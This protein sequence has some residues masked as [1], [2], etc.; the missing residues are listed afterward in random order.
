MAI[1]TMAT[2]YQIKVQRDG[3]RF[4]DF[5]KGLENYKE[6]VSIELSALADMSKGL[7]PTGGALKHGTSL[8]LMYAFDETWDKSWSVQSKGYQKKVLQYWK[9]LSSY[10]IDD[11][12][13]M[14]LEAIDT[15]AIDDYIKVLRAKGNKPKT[16]NNKLNCLSSMLTLMTERRLLKAVPVIHWESVKNNSRPRYFSPE[17]EQQILGLAGDMH[18]HSQWINDL[19][20]DFIILLCDTGMRPWS[21][22]KAIQP[23]WVVRNSNGIRIIRIPRE[24][25]KTDAEREIPLTGRL[26]NVLDKRISTLARG[27][28]IFEKLDYKWHCVEFWDNLVRPVMGWGPKEVWYC[29]RH[30]F[31]TRLCEYSGNLKVTQQLMGHSCITQTARYAKATDKAMC[32]AM[33]SL[34]Y[35]RLKALE[36]SQGTDQTAIN[37]QDRSEDKGGQTHLPTGPSNGLTH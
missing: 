27:D 37:M 32:D 6:A 3:F 33:V 7:R 29:F 31:A 17:E 15:K 5:V 19:L 21:E 4:H 22:A 8:T 20:Q 26:A 9:S 36:E 25:T 34:E 30:T 24:V 18:Y 13:M 10:F 28:L 14:R 11:R 16:I 23:S 2:G 1:Y 12:R 35:G